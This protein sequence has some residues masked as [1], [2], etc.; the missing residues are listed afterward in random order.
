MTSQLEPAPKLRGK[1][2]KYTSDII[3]QGA[4]RLCFIS[5]MSPILHP[6]SI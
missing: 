5:L 3:F 6:V 1:A 2:E 4:V